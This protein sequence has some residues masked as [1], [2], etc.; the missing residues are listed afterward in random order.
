MPEEIERL[1]VAVGANTSALSAGLAGISPMLSKLGGLIANPMV[2]ITAG[3]AIAGV[4]IAKFAMDA[5]K[6]IGTG[7]RAIRTGTGATGK[8]LN[9]FLSV[10]RRSARL[11][12]FTGRLFF[13]RG[14]FSHS[15]F[16]LGPQVLSQQVSDYKN[17]LEILNRQVRLIEFAFHYF[18]KARTHLPPRILQQFRRVAQSISNPANFYNVGSGKDVLKQ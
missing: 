16:I 14:H 4:A 8:E 7:T 12:F 1:T 9:P 6:D 11:S 15:L 3:V 10:C 5:Q 18:K 17:M 2:A 13:Q